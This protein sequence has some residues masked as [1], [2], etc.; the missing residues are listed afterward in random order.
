[1]KALRSVIEGAPKRVIWVHVLDRWP[2]EWRKIRF[3]GVTTM[4]RFLEA[5]K[6]DFVGLV[7]VWAETSPPNRTETVL[8][9]EQPTKQQH[10]AADS[11]AVVNSD[12]SFA[13]VLDQP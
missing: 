12:M 8:G 3:T 9:P 13:I 2:A 7:I 4:L 6:W 11:I 5:V 10:V 1:M